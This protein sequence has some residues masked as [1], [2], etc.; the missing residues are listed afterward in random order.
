M[1]GEFFR[2]RIRPGESLEAAQEIFEDPTQDIDQE[3]KDLLTEVV[4]GDQPDE[5]IEALYHLSNPGRP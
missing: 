3:F 2:S 1:S 4:V 5:S